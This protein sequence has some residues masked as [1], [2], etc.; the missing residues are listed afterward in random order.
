[1]IENRQPIDL[2]NSLTFISGFRIIEQFCSELNPSS[3]AYEWSSNWQIQMSWNEI[4]PSD[5]SLLMISELH[6]TSLKQFSFQC[7]EIL[8]SPTNYFVIE[9]EKFMMLHKYLKIFCQH[10]AENLPYFQKLKLLTKHLH[11]NKK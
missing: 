7:F 2:F 10:F 8:I 1:M 11:S 6:Q 9:M 4:K 5:E 3:T